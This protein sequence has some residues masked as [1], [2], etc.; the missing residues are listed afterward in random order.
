MD[1]R[2]T[3][4]T[5][6]STGSPSL[7][8]SSFFSSLKKRHSVPCVII[9]CGLLL[10]HPDSCR[11]ERRSGSCSRGHI[12]ATGLEEITVMTGE[13][14]YALVLCLCHE[15]CDLPQQPVA[16]N[17]D[18][19]DTIRFL[20][21]RLHEVGMITSVPQRLSRRGTVMTLLHERRRPEG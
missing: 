1:G 6:C 8:L 18:P 20:A 2:D 11:A 17:S 10:D 12:R 7:S 5:A 3:G 21:L 15:V 16:A 4:F 19:E 14:S 9:F 13:Q